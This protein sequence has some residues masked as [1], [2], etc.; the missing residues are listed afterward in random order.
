MNS[1]VSRRRQD[2]STAGQARHT[3]KYARQRVQLL[4]Q[5]DLAVVGWFSV[6]IFARKIIKSQVSVLQKKKLIRR[7]FV[8]DE[9]L[10]I[11][12][13]AMKPLNVQNVY[14]KTVP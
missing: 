9:N 11:R 8:Q 4:R 2:I 13:N 14:Y 5:R 3:E 10:S 12:H 6:S 7:R 1:G